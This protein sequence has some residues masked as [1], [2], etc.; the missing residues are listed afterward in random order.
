MPPPLGKGAL[1][2]DARL[3]SDVCLVVYIGPKR[4][5]ERPRRTKIGKEV[6][7]VTRDSDITFKVKSSKVSLQGA[8]HIV[9]ASRTVVIVRLDALTLSV[10]ATATWM[11]G[12]V[13]GCLSQPVLYQND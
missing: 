10:I 11:G 9:A 2:D 4:G 12:W 13:A 3:T 1:S 5:T 8:G 7:H 6:G